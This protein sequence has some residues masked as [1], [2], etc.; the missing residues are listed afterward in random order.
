M[1][2]AL[3]TATRKR[4]PNGAVLYHG[5]SA[6]DG[7][8]IV[9]ILTG[10]AVA[11]GNT[12][13]GAML[14]TWIMRADKRPHHAVRDKSDASVCGDCPHAGTTCYVIVEH[15]PLA[16]YK[17]WQRGSYH[18]WTGAFPNH[19]LRGKRVRL[20]AYGDPAAVPFNTWRRVMAQK[21]SGWTGYTHQWRKPEFQRF[22]SLLM[23]SVDSLAEMVQAQLDGWRTFRVR[24]EGAPITKG[25][26]GCP[27]S[28]EMG[29]KS[30]CVKC[31]LCSGQGSGAKSVSIIVHG[32]RAKGFVGP[33]EASED[34]KL[35]RKWEREGS[36]A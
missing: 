10:L 3:P 19:A 4:K 2:K 9:V 8:M 11:S 27:A 1:T 13:T 35:I 31:S 22:R 33:M 29:K 20:G 24:G 15:A 16:I 18:D 28:E 21:P 32:Y 17:A 25:E 7:Q 34:Q 6:L 12:K 5:P 14:Q 23:A 30:S 26:V 36:L